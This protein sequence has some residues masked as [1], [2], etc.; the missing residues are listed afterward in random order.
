MIL[1]FDDKID[2]EK[3]NLKKFTSNTITSIT[4]LQKEID[5]IK[6]RGYA[7]DSEEY[8]FGLKSVA[9]PYF[10]KRNEFQGAV[11]VS[12][13]SVRLEDETLHKFGQEIF[14]VVNGHM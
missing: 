8:E 2:L 13:L 5:S 12:G 11:G 6:Q 3:L 9:V 14:K 7:I 10:N 1:A 4:K